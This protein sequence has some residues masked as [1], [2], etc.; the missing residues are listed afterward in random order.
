MGSNSDRRLPWTCVIRPKR[1][2][3]LCFFHDLDIIICFA[4]LLYLFT[5]IWTN[6]LTQCTQC[7]FLSADVYFARGFIQFSEARKNPEKIYKKISKTEASGSP[8]EGERGARGLPGGLLARPGP[9]LHQEVAWVGP[10]SFVAL[11]WPIF[12]VP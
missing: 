8:K 5:H 11:L 10:T 1:I 12:S 6:L 9:R 2:Y 7:Q 4:T 3:N